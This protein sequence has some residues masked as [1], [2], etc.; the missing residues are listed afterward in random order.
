MARHGQF[1]TLWVEM[2]ER[3]GLDVDADRCRLGRGRARWP[4]SP[5]AWP[6]TGTGEI[7][8]VFV[9]HNETATGVTS[10]VAGVRAAL[11]D[12][13]PRRAAVRRRRV[14]HRL[15]R[16]PD[17]RLG[18]RPCRH[19]QPEGPDVPAGLGILAVSPKA[20]EAS[21]TRHDAPRPI[22]E[23]RDMLAMTRHAAI[24]P[25]RRPTPAAPRPARGARPHPRRRAG[26]RL[27]PPSPPCRRRPRAASPPGACE[28]V[29]EQ[30]SLASN[31]VTA[32]R[33]PEG[34]DAREVIRIGYDA[35]QHLVRLGPGA[36]GGQGL[37]HRPSGRSERRHVPDRACRRRNGAG[38][39]GGRRRP[40]ARASP[41]R[42]R[43]M[44]RPRA[45]PLQLAAE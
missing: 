29:R 38:R 13:L 9:T 33:V 37:P 30:P 31:T 18:R 34:V 12:G 10:D 14:L 6:P 25:T 11:D 24:S 7:K 23:F 4:N 26:H 39:G 28:T 44:P 2:A 36:A 42:R 20:L 19:R 32:I 17:G 15:D 8:A 35:L 21:K 3:L 27:R 45:P 16:L 41:P 40:S 5:A 22:F 1:S 43:G